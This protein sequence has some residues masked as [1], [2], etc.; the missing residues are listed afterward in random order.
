LYQTSGGEESKLASNRDG[1][2]NTITKYWRDNDGQPLF[3]CEG[4]AAAKVTTIS[5]S[6]YLSSVF[7]Q[8]LPASRKSLT[9]YGWSIGEQDTHILKQL[10]LSNCQKAAVS[11][12]RNGRNE[13]QLAKEKD[14]MS[15]ML[16]IYAGIKQVEF[17]DAE[18]AGC[19]ANE[20]RI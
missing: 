6:K 11:V 18:S 12:Y 14:S 19:W 16:R 8:A 5:Q 3:V 17:Y 1:L 10:A 15:D 2:L 4:S 9:I 13:K 20:E 7:Q